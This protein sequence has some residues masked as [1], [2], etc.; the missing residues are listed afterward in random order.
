MRSFSASL[1]VVI[2]IAYSPWAIASTCTS[3]VQIEVTAIPDIPDI[4]LDQIS[5]RVIES[6]TQA[7]IVERKSQKS[8]ILVDMPCGRY[9]LNVFRGGFVSQ[10]IQLVA[11][12]PRILARVGLTVALADTGLSGSIS[13]TVDH[14]L[15]TP[16]EMWVE[17]I[18]I[19]HQDST[20]ECIVDS[21]YSFKADEMRSG[22]YIIALLRKKDASLIAAKT[23][24][25]FGGSRVS[26]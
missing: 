15:G 20:R 7:V 3:R 11:Y 18:P 14:S 22:P 13:G 21:D 4:P 17:V 25:V 1:S 5:I 6:G 23:I 12:Q 26:F 10:P 8:P 2:F 24:V 19:L 16:D 9:L